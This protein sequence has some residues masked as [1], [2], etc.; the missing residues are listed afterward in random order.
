MLVIPSGY[1][2]GFTKSMNQPMY[3][4]FSTNYYWVHDGTTTLAAVIGRGLPTWI[5]ISKTYSEVVMCA[6]A[7]D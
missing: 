6:V 4:Q 3:N 7:L 1:I 2:L 5:L